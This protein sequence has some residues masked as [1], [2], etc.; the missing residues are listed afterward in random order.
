MC[1]AKVGV[2][3]DD[4][5]KQLAEAIQLLATRPDSKEG[6]ALRSRINAQLAPVSDAWDA[7]LAPV[8]E[9]LERPGSSEAAERARVAEAACVELVGEV[10]EGMRGHLLA[11]ANRALHARRIGPPEIDEILG[12]AVDDA[13]YA[14][15]LGMQGP[16][17]VWHR[18]WAILCLVDEGL[19]SAAQAE[20]GL[21]ELRAEFESMLGREVTSTEW[22]RLNERVKART[23]YLQRV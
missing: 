15:Q 17:G 3:M 8:V 1:Q 11:E 4:I 5:R 18:L 2:P 6:L 23:A 20:T 22:A 19:V 10:D 12:E 14:L 21:L 16:R 13:L 7:W 9:Q